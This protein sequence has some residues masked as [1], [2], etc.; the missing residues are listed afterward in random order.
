M[1]DL[2]IDDVLDLTTSLLPST[3]IDDRCDPY[4]IY[5]DLNQNDDGL[6]SL[7][8]REDNTYALGENT[9]YPSCTFWNMG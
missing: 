6:Y 3:E 8:D 2:S 1:V 5:I 4:F 7:Q 9:H